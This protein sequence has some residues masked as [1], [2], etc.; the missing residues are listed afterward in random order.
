MQRSVA[1]K[2]GIKDGMRAYIAGAPAAALRVIDL[3]PL[4]LGLTLR[5][6]FNYIHLFVL[7]QAEMAD[8]FPR[9]K[10]HLGTGG[11]LWV[12][13]PK[14]RRLGTDLTLP[15]V[16]RIGYEHGLVEST[17]LSVDSTW[18][19]IKFTHPKPGKVYRNRYGT[20]PNG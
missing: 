16:I 14:G 1:Q 3:P 12:S 19:A 10:T 2:M 9:L 7:T 18:S 4:D 8:A 15:H 20:L 5:G 11:M 13:W 17:T 6:D